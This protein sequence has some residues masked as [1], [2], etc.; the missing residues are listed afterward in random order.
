MKTLLSLLL[1]CI[2]FTTNAAERNS[3][4]VGLEAT[5]LRCEYLVDP[6]GIDSPE[7]RFS[8]KIRPVA[9]AR[10]LKQ[11]AWQVKVTD[12][13]G[14]LLWDSGKVLSE[15]SVNI[16]Y[17]GKKLSSNQDCR[18]KVRLWGSAAQ[19]GPWSEN[20]RF[21]MALLDENDWEGPWIRFRIAQDI[22]HIW[23]RKSFELEERPARAILHLAS[24]GYHELY[25]NGQRVD[26]RVL[27][28]SVSN[29]KKKVFYVSYDVQPFLR[30]GE[31]V[32]GVWAGSGWARADG[33][34]GKGVWEQDSLIRC[35]LYTSSGFSLHSDESWKA[36]VS[37]MRYRG[38]WKGG[39]RGEYG[40]EVWDARLKVDDWNQTGYDD[41]LWLNATAYT[42]EGLS[43]R[44][45]YIRDFLIKTAN[46]KELK[47]QMHEPDRKIRQMKPVSMS[48]DPA[49]DRARF[50]MGTNFTGW[51]EF[52]L[53]KG[54]EGQR[55][56][57]KTANREEMVE[58]FDQLSVYIHDGSGEGTF[59]H[60]FNYMA[61]RWMT[62][63]GLGYEPNIEDLRGYLI[64]NDRA[65][66][67]SF[68]CSDPLFNR[69]Y[70]SDLATYIANTVNGVTMDCPHRE[71]YG[72]GEIALACSWGP[73]I[74][75]YESAAYYQK[76]IQ[77][78]IDVQRDDGFVNTIAPQVYRGAG[79]AL[80]SSAPAT[81]G[82]EF[83]RA[84]GDLR[85]LEESY[86]SMKKWVDYLH[87]HVSEEGV[88]TAYESPSRFLGDWATPHGSEYGNTEA[89]K[90]FNNC[91][92][93]YCLDVTAKSARALGKTDEAA[94]YEQ[95]LA[96]LR[97]SVHRKWYN[98]ATGLY[99]DGRQL[100]LAFP[101]FV[102][103]TPEHLREAVLEKF[104]EEIKVN[105]PYLDTGSS[106]LPI[107]LKFVVDHLKQP[108]LIYHCLKSTDMPSYG[109]FLKRGQTTWPEYWKV[110][111]V[112]SRIHTCYTGISGWF[113]RGVAG[114][115]PDPEHPGM[116][117]FLIE[118][119]LVGDL[120]WAKA[121]S[122][123]LYGE[124]VSEW[125]RDGAY[126]SF[127]IEIPPNTTATLRI[128]S[129]AASDVREG[130]VPAA[131]AE[132]VRFL[133]AGNGSALFEVASGSY[134][135]T[136]RLE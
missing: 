94:V 32:V 50:D 98:E 134:R 72:Y 54:T 31:N 66:I 89:A 5:D 83:Y 106:G 65:R 108:D 27:A 110:E 114:I 62:V 79:G 75:N 112:P 80:W 49:T 28:P 125:S 4:A 11:T 21:V 122:A 9:N 37:H 58:E 45:Y 64:T 128:P 16:A 86:A 132:G 127:V 88:L 25:I 85:Q 48:Y 90:L 74:P 100:S 69:I 81:L 131:R 84:Y 115:Q 2:G 22:D 135:F 35:Q 42:K 97:P 56:L 124:I 73:G 59:S 17:A 133:G 77:D 102:G 53:R 101:L 107:M 117:R 104:V 116:Q 93:A 118:P 30:A 130:G 46:D 47:A 111:D 3:G 18:W 99:H 71:R 82:W 57:F 60:R 78:W 6:V 95:R 36:R 87:A 76:V 29:L 51:L 41:R 109:Y 7:P 23:Y 91:V 20:A 63:E 44:R 121:R 24:I 26:E 10:G 96:E 68:E 13:D 113:T 15:D 92:Y 1:I 123:S 40:G 67:G 38:K 119:K 70:E 8:W 39:G 12:A 105:K 61:G 52:D 103:V 34:F 55:V 136:S 126:A 14:V 19:P 33:S 43:S 129:I 120:E